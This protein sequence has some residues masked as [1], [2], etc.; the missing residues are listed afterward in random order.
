MWLFLMAAVVYDWRAISAGT[1]C[2]YIGL[3]GL[4]LYMLWRGARARMRLRTQDEGWRPRYMDDV[5]FN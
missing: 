3:L 1:R 2:L 5:G 4:G